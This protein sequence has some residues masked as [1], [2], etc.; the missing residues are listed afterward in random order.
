MRSP[1]G[2]QILKYQELIRRLETRGTHE[3]PE[4]YVRKI[5]AELKERVAQTE[6]KHRWMRC[7]A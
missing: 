7:A 4:Q 5:V 6:H 1:A 3:L 2:K